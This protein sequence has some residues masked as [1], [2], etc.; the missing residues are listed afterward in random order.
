MD[1]EVLKR[2]NG[3][4]ALPG[5]R[6]ETSDTI[7]A[8]V[9][10]FAGQIEDLSKRLNNALRREADQDLRIIDLEYRIEEWRKKNEELVIENGQLKNERSL[11]Q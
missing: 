1:Q 8:M 4:R 6:T 9:V 2:R 5:G 10:A 11:R 3:M 7:N